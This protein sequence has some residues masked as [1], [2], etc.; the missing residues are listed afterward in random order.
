[1]TSGDNSSHNGGFANTERGCFMTVPKDEDEMVAVFL[2]YADLD[3][4][5]HHAIHLRK[6][7]RKARNMA[8]CLIKA[9]GNWYKCEYSKAGCRL[10][11]KSLWPGVIDRAYDNV[12]GRFIACDDEDPIDGKPILD[13]WMKEARAG[14]SPSVLYSFRV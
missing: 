1:M 12:L 4:I 11:D 14:V 5:I 6:N 8:V 10:I 7:K 2:D 3:D 13:L 9:I